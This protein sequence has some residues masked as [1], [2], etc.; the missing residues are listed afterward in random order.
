MTYRVLVI[1]SDEGFA[2]SCPELPGCHSQG[3]TEAEALD[4]IRDAILEWLAA[5]VDESDRVSVREVTVG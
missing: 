3:R 5:Q 2:V 1:Q 4:N